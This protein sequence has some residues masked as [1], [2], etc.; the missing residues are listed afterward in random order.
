MTG[1]ERPP[2]T[3]TDAFERALAARSSERY[4]LRLYVADSTP[5]ALA[6]IR[7]VK[8]IC[9]ERLRDRY[10]LEVVDI[11]ENPAAMT[12]D[13]VLATPTLI[14]RLPTPLRTVIDDLSEE[15]DAIVALDLVPVD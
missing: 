10:E 13:V 4:V 9:E 8:R 15:R 6:A 12:E 1:D 11:Y 7:N 5:R 2:A 14:R 3:A